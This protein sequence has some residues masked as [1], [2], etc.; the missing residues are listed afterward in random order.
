MRRAS[1]HRFSVKDRGRIR[2]FDSTADMN[3]ADITGVDTASDPY[4][5]NVVALLHMNGANKSS[6]YTDVTGKTWTRTGSIEITNAAKKFGTGSSYHDGT[7]LI[8]TPNHADFNFGTGDF[9][10][11]AWAWFTS[12]ATARCIVGNYQGTTAG[13]TLQ[14]NSSGKLGF[15]CTGDGFDVTS[16]STLVANRWYHLAA[17]RAGTS[18]KLFLDG[19]QEASAT[20]SQNIT[21]TAVCAIGRIATVAT[22]FHGG[23]IDEVRITKG[24][25]RYTGTFSPPLAAFPD[26]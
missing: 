3:D 22:A 18:L 23:F 26:N 21:S 4:F 8:S 11:E 25:A 10:V 17:A 5:A 15:N 20:D 2:G 12:F 7:G 16:A 1:F 6:T 13:W 14:V 19:V 9:T 24:V